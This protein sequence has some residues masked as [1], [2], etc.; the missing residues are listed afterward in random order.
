MV[1]LEEWKKKLN[2]KPRNGIRFVKGDKYF[3]S[4]SIL[5]GNC[6]TEDLGALHDSNFAKWILIEMYKR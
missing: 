1:C 4:G 2:Q 5:F 3:A 6:I